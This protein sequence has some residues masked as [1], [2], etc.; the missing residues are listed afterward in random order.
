M[1]PE[2]AAASV[3]GVP[4]TNRTVWQCLDTLWLDCGFIPAKQVGV[5]RFDLLGGN[6]NAVVHLA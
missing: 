4:S 1:G 2:C 5:I 3:G 6:E